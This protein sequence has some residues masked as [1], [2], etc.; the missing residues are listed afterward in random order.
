MGRR[1][2]TAM[3]LLAAGSWILGGGLLLVAEVREARGLAELQELRASMA[4]RGGVV[5]VRNAEDCAA[6]AG[7]V[8]LAATALQERGVV[9]QGVIL[10]RGP[11]DVAVRLASEAFPHRTLS[12]EAA[13]AMAALGL[14]P[15]PLAMVVGPS[16]AVVKVEALAGRSSSAILESLGTP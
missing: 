1:L 6:T 10:K 5:F 13:S 8:E 12:M 7:P 11:V 4:G 9:V 2:L 14:G 15:T 16:G 3:R